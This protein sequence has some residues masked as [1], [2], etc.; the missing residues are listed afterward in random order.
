MVRIRWVRFVS[1][2]TFCGKE[3]RDRFVIGQNVIVVFD[4]KIGFGKVVDTS[5]M[6]GVTH[7]HVDNF[8]CRKRQGKNRVYSLV[9]NECIFHLYEKEKAQ[10]LF[11]L[12]FNEFVKDS[13]HG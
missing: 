1:G 9:P 12:Q 8:K 2:G 5:L 3:M 13:K 11:D 4:R 7:Y 6:E 10:E